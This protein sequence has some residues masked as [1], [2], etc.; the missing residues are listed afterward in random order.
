[1]LINLLPDFLA[2]LNSSDPTT[3]YLAYFEAHRQI[4]EAYWDNYVVGVD[5]PHFMEVVH[6]AATARRGDLRAMLERNDVITL[7]REAERASAALL[8][9]DVDF[10]VVL[11]VGVGAANAGELVVGGR[12]IAFVC[13]E[14]FTSVQNPESRGLGLD[15][16]LIPM[17]IGHEIAHAVRYTS[18]TTRSEMSRA[19]AENEGY[20]SYWETG[21]RVPLKELLINEGLATHTSRQVSPGHAAWHYYGYGRRQYA[22]IR[23]VE[24]VINMAIDADLER[25]GLGLRLRYLSGGL[26]DEARTVDRVVLPERAGYYLGALMADNA[27]RANGL[28]WAI[29][30]SA[31]EILDLGARAAASA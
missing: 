26:T 11:M 31:E 19:I 16:E 28:A 10:D 20:Y 5:S 7:A 17:W 8:E 3:A 22:R 12:G 21:K 13:L 4:L 27:I 30:A 14:H 1:M 23:E 2:V 18:P 25:T 29:R 6:A 24:P 15:P 9:T